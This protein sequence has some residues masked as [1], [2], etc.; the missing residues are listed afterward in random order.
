MA[1]SPAGL[2]LASRWRL[3][4]RRAWLIAWASWGGFVQ[5]VRGSFTIRWKPTPLPL[6]PDQ[7]RA[8]IDLSQT[9]LSPFCQGKDEKPRT[10]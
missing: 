1:P 2:A 4:G 10:R 6:F 3:L 7:N 5:E 9:F 8:I